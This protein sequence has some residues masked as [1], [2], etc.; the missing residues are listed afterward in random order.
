MDILFNWSAFRTLRAEL[1]DSERI[2][3]QK[4]FQTHLVGNP[5]LD[6]ES[7]PSS[8]ELEYQYTIFE[9]AWIMRSMWTR[10]K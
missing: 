10:N 9:A 4:M 1:S 3:I 7:E 5:P 6:G 8:A 2:L